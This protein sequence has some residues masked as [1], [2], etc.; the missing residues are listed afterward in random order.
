MEDMYWGVFVPS[1]LTAT[2]NFSC[3]LC[4]TVPLRSSGI[5]KRPCCSDQD[6]DPF[7][8]QLY[9]IALGEFHGDRLLVNLFAELFDNGVKR[10]LVVVR[11]GF[12]PGVEAIAD[13]RGRAVVTACDDHSI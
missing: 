1:H 5:A 13:R 11:I 8:R 6:L 4:A 12:E 10:K 3:E 9:P 7:S 2:P